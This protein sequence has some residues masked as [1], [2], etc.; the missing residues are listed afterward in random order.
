MIDNDFGANMTKEAKEESRLGKRLC[1]ML[2]TLD[3]QYDGDGWK[4]ASWQI[5]RFQLLTAI[6]DPNVTSRLESEATVGEM[7]TSW[8]LFTW[9]YNVCL[10]Q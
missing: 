10:K 9:K 5:R 4:G 7:Q 2:N 8:L 6:A 1:W 3:D